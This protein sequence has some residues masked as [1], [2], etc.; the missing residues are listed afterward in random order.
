MR[1]KLW[2]AA[3]TLFFACL[4]AGTYPFWSSWLWPPAFSGGKDGQTHVEEVQRV[5]LSLPARANLRLKVAKVFP[6]QQPQTRHLPVPG[7]VIEHPGSCERIIAAPLAGVVQQLNYVRGDL[8]R[9]GDPLFTLRIT[10]EPLHASQAGLFK[11]KQELQ[12][13]QDEKKRLQEAA[14]QGAVPSSRLIEV[15]NQLRLLEAGAR[16]HERDLAA[17][18]LSEKD[19]EQA[20]QGR[21]LTQIRVMVPEFQHGPNHEPIASSSQDHVY[22]LEEMKVLLG[23]QVQAGQPLCVLAD[24]HLLAIEGRVAASETPLIQQAARKGWK[25]QA[26]FPRDDA[27][28]WPAYQP[29]LRITSLANRLDAEPQVLRFLVPLPNQHQDYQRGGKTYRLWRFR[30]GQ[31]V[32]V[33]IPVETINDVFVLP[34]AAVAREGPEA[35]V[36]VENGDYFERLSV[37]VVHAD[38]HT[39]MVANDGSLFPGTTIATSGAVQLNWALKAQAGE[40]AGHHHDHDH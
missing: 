18:G 10:S 6:A 21:F 37:H 15:D 9:P 1:W 39:V 16:S 35:Y 11:V 17:R 5:R 7:W 20:G 3:L 26:D 24:H 27:A 19:I 23:E 32:Q 31:R 36:F 33:K 30:P 22:E 8:L 29:D 40:G 2:V 12:I 25:V 34:A 28:A 38:R 13:T 4:G 14:R